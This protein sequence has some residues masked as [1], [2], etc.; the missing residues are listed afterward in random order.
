MKTNIEFNYDLDKL[1]FNKPV[2]LL[3]HGAILHT[4]RKVKGVAHQYPNS[5][6]EKRID[7]IAYEPIGIS[8]TYS[9]EPYFTSDPIAWSYV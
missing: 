8:A 2:V 9:A 3:F 6:Y 7:F 4:G 1:P 5:K